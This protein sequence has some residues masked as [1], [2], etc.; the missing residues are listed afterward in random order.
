MIEELFGYIYFAQQFSNLQFP[1]SVR[2][3][4]LGIF[5]L[6]HLVYHKISTSS[7]G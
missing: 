7:F 1:D 5:I 6:V 2:K 3:Q 4:I